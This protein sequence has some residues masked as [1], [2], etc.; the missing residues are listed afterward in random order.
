MSDNKKLGIVLAVTTILLIVLSF[1]EKKLE[2]RIQNR[3]G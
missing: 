1:I 2:N 3:K